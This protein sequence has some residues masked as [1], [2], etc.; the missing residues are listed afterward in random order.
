MSTKESTEDGSRLLP[1]SD[2]WITTE[3]AARR[4][5]VKPETF[6]RSRLSENLRRKS[7]SLDPGK[8][9]RGVGALWSAEDIAAC[10]AVRRTVRVPLS[11]AAKFVRAMRDGDLER[12][13]AEL[14]A[15]A[16]EEL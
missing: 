6:W 5:N 14:R 16:S 7:R 2:E 4:L 9:F 8:S 12:E 1:P 10:A 11:A 3:E 15:A 13:L